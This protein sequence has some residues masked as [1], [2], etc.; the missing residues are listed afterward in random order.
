M[1]YSGSYYSKLVRA[2]AWEKGAKWKHYEINFLGGEH[3][4]DWYVKRN[5]ASTVPTMYVG[6]KMKVVTESSDIMDYIDRE[7]DG[8][9]KL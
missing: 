9:V 4:S 2:V 1:S 7:F 6:S 8:A 3:R 5:K